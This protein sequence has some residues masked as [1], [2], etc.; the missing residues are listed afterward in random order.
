M[1]NAARILTLVAAAMPMFA[2][3]S[4]TATRREIEVAAAALLW[5][6]GWSQ[7]TIK[8]GGLSHDRR[9][10][11]ENAGRV[12]QTGRDFACDLGR[13][14]EFQMGPGNRWPQPSEPEFLSKGK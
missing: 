8:A 7:E 12:S 9:V 1:T 6:R 11:R 10:L 4:I 3:H 2:H 5:A 13:W 14:S